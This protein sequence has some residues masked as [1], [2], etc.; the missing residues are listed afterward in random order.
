M[1]ITYTVRDLHATNPEDYGPDSFDILATFP[2]GTTRYSDDIYVSED[3]A[4][5]VIAGLELSGEDVS[6]WGRA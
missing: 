3:A 4:A 1:K 2:D 6:Y 5:I